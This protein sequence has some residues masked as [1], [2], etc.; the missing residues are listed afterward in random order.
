M[1][2]RHWVAVFMLA[3][4]MSCGGSTSVGVTFDSD[5]LRL[6]LWTG[7]FNAYRILDADNQG[8]AFFIDTGCLYNYQTGRQNNS[9]CIT[10]GGNIVQYQGFVIRIVNIRLTNG[11][12]ASALVDETTANFIDIELDRWGREVIFVTSLQPALCIV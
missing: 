8:F 4:L 7:N 12:C 6:I 9:F 2:A 11:V 5:G 3:L 10:S 1:R